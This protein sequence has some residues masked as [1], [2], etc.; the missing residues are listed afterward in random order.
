MPRAP[1]QVL[2]L[3]F[4]RSPEGDWQYGLL[5]RSDDGN[6]QGVAGGGED[7]ERPFEAALREVEEEAGWPAAKVTLFDLDTRDSVQA[8]CFA[9]RP[10]WPADLYVVPQHFFAMNAGTLEFELSD[11]H[12]EFAW[13][14]YEAAYQALRF[15]S[16]KTALWELRERLQVDD[17]RPR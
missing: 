3:P 8:A 9:A 1:F 4:R 5:R 10:L 12:T 16:N 7:D 13:F 11:E 15:D 2:V 17:L 14:C 6:W